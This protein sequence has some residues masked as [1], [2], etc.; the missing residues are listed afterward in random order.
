[1]QLLFMV[2]KPFSYKFSCRLSIRSI[3][4]HYSMVEHFIQNP[5]QLCI[6]NKYLQFYLRKD[7]LLDKL[8][9][10]ILYKVGENASYI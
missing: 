10:I 1:M 3:I 6:A 9:N 4:Q 2:I 7:W 5:R 8:K